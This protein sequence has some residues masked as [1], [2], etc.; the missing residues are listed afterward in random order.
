MQIKFKK[1]HQK[2]KLPKYALPGDAG[3]DLF[4]VEDLIINPGQIVAI[5]TGLEAEIAEGTA[6]LIWD[7][8]GLA[9]KKGIKTMGGAID[10]GYRG[11]IAVIV[12]NLSDKKHEV[13]CGDKIAQMIVQKIEKPT[14]IETDKLNQSSRGDRGFGSTGH[15]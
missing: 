11:E 10:A 13:C 1:I 9:V 8:S 14:I 2:A 3:M 15:K 5:K 7:K 12:V 6:G 4:S